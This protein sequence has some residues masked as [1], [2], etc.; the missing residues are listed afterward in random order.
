MTTV[1]TNVM[2]SPIDQ[3]PRA[4]TVWMIY[5]LVPHFYFC[6]QPKCLATLRFI[7]S[8]YIRLFPLSLSDTV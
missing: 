5:H 2:P 6:A 4:R 7:S 8:R 1:M 3:Q